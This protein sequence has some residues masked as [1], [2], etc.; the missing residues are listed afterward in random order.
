ML[1]VDDEGLPEPFTG[2][3]WVTQVPFN[4]LC[5]N[6]RAGTSNAGAQRGREAR[7]GQPFHG[8]LLTRPGWRG[9]VLALGR[10][11]AT[12]GAASLPHCE[13]RVGGT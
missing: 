11:G 8:C 7:D 13:H 10:R 6:A 1:Q 5:A 3:S 2:P 12:M 4:A 9:G